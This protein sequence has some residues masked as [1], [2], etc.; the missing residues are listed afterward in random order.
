MTAETIVGVAITAAGVLI[1]GIITIVV[2]VWVERLRS[3]RVSL[4]V[5]DLLTI[6]PRGRFNN[7]WRA[8][9]VKVS[10]DR[11][12]GWADW[13]LSRLPAQGC[14]AEIAFLRPDGSPLFAGSMS[15][16]WAGSAEPILLPVQTPTGVSQILANSEQLKSTV[17]IYP[18]EAE[19][20]DVAIRVDQ[21]NSAYGWNNDSYFHQDWRNP[22]RELVQGRYLVEVTIRSTGPKCQKRFR[23][24]NDGRPFDSLRLTEL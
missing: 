20:L 1:G 9:H 19:E 15:G 10:N 17:D 6:P 8:A 12:P 7:R 11:L 4:A 24:E 2:T 13:W 23:I 22:N 18:G 16:R 3:P 21:E 5:G 14:R